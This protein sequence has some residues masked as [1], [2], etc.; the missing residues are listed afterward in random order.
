V[1]DALAYGVKV[2][3][4]TVHF[5]DE[6]V[7]TGP[8]ILQEAVPVLPDDDEKSLHQRLHE[9]EYRL[10]PRAIRYFCEGRL[11]VEGRKVRILEEP[12]GAGEK[13]A[14]GSP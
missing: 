5:V 4:V 14:A 13:D 11:V 2:T 3:G 12:A 1:A 6:G 9:V 8:V 10:Y 7:D